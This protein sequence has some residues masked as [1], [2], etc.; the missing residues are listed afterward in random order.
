MIFEC[1]HKQVTE[2][3]KAVSHIT[4]TIK[5][6]GHGCTFLVKV[7]ESGLLG[8]CFPGIGVRVKLLLGV[9]MDAVVV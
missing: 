5:R 1:L 4:I 7:T 6:G 8:T 3:K 9:Q 2:T